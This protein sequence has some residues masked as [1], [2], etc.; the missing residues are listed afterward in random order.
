[1]HLILYKEEETPTVWKLVF[2]ALCMHRWW[3]I[4]Y[5]TMKQETGEHNKIRRPTEATVWLLLRL[6]CWKPDK[7]IEDHLDK[8]KLI[9][10]FGQPEWWLVE[11]HHSMLSLNVLS[12]FAFTQRNIWRRWH[13]R[14]HVHHWLS[15]VVVCFTRITVEARLKKS[16]WVKRDGLQKW[17]ITQSL[18]TSLKPE[19]SWKVNWKDLNE[20]LILCYSCFL[21]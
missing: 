4:W 7:I 14:G 2:L 9:S 5:S 18:W 17:I 3:K 15:S 1:M 8:L 20:I 6:L 19:T 12:T 10:H 21:S 13:I 11:K 16:H